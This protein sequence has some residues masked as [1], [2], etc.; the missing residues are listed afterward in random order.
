MQGRILAEE[1]C[2]SAP[3][4]RIFGTML[5]LSLLAVAWN[6]LALVLGWFGIILPGADNGLI[7]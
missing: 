4:D 1:L 6:I 2:Y 3:M 7:G 5:F